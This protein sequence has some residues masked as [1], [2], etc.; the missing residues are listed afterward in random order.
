MDVT[1]TI[2]FSF[3]P[4]LPPPHLPSFL[5]LSSRTFFQVQQKSC[6]LKNRVAIGRGGEG[7]GEEEE[8][9]IYIKRGKDGEQIGMRIDRNGQEEEE[10]ERRQGSG[11]RQGKEEE[12]EEKE[13]EEGRGC[14][15][16]G[17]HNGVHCGSVSLSAWPVFANGV[18]SPSWSAV[19]PL[20]P[21]SSLCLSLS[22]SSSCIFTS[23]CPSLSPSLFLGLSF[24]SSLSSL[25]SFLFLSLK[26]HY[27]S[28]QKLLR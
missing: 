20:P 16:K 9:E 3:S 12:E 23:L 27:N 2:S 18:H 28:T 26:C 4:P 14:W 5:L 7:E 25:S 11:R 19:P 22:T 10:K 6:F 17:A 8:E 13:E 24:L 21:P 1:A 15:A